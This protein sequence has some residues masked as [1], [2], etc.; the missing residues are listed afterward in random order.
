MKQIAALL[1]S[2]LVVMFAT[3]SARAADKCVV[4]YRSTTPPT[5]WQEACAREAA[6]RLAEFG[7]E[8]IAYTPAA[9]GLGDAG[10]IEY[11]HEKGAVLLVLVSGQWDE[12]VEDEVCF[13]VCCDLEVFCVDVETGETISSKTGGDRKLTCKGKKGLPRA[14]SQTGTK[15]ARTATGEVIDDLV[16]RFPGRIF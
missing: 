7:L 6:D 15:A 9:N 2:V 3:V 10:L 16:I 14:R 13:Q 8:T 11:C 5:P 1:I 12:I 4:A